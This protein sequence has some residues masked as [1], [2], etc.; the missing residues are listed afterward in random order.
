MWDIIY[1]DKINYVFQSPFQSYPLDFFTPDFHKNRQSSIEER[2]DK[3]KDYKKE[4]I[5]REI[6]S[7]FENKSNIV[8][9]FLNWSSNIISEECLLKIALG[10]GMYILSKIFEEMSKN[11]KLMIRGKSFSSNRN[12]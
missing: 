9:P 8:T 4:D 10:I 6:R 11:L 12:A 3:L 1:Y 2:L 5:K 7:I